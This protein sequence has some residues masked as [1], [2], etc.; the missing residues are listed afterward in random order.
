MICVKKSRAREKVHH[1]TTARAV[2][3]QHSSTSTFNKGTGS[4]A[5]TATTS[6]EPHQFSVQQYAVDD[7]LDVGGL[8]PVCLQGS[9]FPQLI[10]KGP[11]PGDVSKLGCE[12]DNVCDASLDRLYRKPAAASED[13]RHLSR[14]G[15]HRE[16]SWR[17]SKNVKQSR[18]AR[19]HVQL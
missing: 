5:P 8:A 2:H 4:F 15:A 12:Q 6:A 18:K 7:L 1:I 19:R 17:Q 9:L 13:S 14:I 16:P 10:S 3:N 11:F